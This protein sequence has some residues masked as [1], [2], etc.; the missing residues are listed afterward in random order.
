MSH[1]RAPWFSPLLSAT[2]AASRLFSIRHGRTQRDFSHYETNAQMRPSGTQI[3]FQFKYDYYLDY[4]N[5]D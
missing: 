4:R 5:Q 1:R 3:N 2:A